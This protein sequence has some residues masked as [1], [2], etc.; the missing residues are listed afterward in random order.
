M[1]AVDTNVLLRLFIIDA[2][3]QAAAVQNLIDDV[4]R[5][6][7]SV[8]LSPLVLAELCWAMGKI[9][10]KP[11]SDMLDSLQVLLDNNLFAIADREA[12]EVAVE[13]WTTGKADFADYL[14]AAMAREA[15]ARTTFTFDREAAKMRPAFTLLEE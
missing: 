8:F 1:I 5:V 6:G 14:I 13:A 7:D 15:G 3:A 11:K 4:R 10:R 12:V 2:P 9:Y